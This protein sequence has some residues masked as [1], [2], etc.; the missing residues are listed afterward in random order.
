M[1][2]MGLGHR[3]HKRF[4]T[5]VRGKGS[6]EIIL[7]KCLEGRSRQFCCVLL[8]LDFCTGLSKS[9]S[10][11][12]LGDDRGQDSSFGALTQSEQCLSCLHEDLNSI[13]NT[14]ANLLILPPE[15]QRCGGGGVGGSLE[16]TDQR[17]SQIG[18][19]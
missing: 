8:L 5:R 13:P 12:L 10:P 2:W 7:A 14:Q 19:L 18:K 16:L 6:S 4:L 11:C 15:K 9:V 17:S 1:A 3:S